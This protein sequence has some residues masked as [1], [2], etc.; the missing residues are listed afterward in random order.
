VHFK[1]K[2]P[3]RTGEVV[4]ELAGIEKAYDSPEG[5]RNVVYG[6]PAGKPLDLT[7]YRGDKVCL[8]GPNGAGKSTLLKIVADALAP[9]KGQ[10]K[11]G[12]HVSSAYYAQHQ[13]EQLDAGNTVFAELDRAA[14][15]WTQSEV[16]KLLGAFLFKG[17]DVEKKVSV[18]SGGEKSR[19]ALA[20]MLVEPAP[21]LCLDEP[22]NHLDIAS[23]DIL[24]AALKAYEGTL[25]FITHDRHLIRAVANRII[26]VKDGIVTNYD[27]D[28]DY[29]LSKTEDD[30]SQPVGDARKPAG[31]ARKPAGD[32]RTPVGATCGRAGDG[33]DASATEAASPPTPRR[34]KLA[35]TEDTGPKTKE[36][37]RAEAEARNRFAKERRE[38]KALEA[39]LNN[40]QARHDELVACM[41]SEELYNDKEAFDRTLTEYQQLKTLIPKLEEEWYSLSLLIEEK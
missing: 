25:V 9:D 1:F 10:R 24:E 16:R 4:V 5:G 34:A 3:P 27:G 20:K 2:Q 31:D 28:Y 6:P 15:S 8:V 26:E 21:L 12:V 32:V 41:A 33:Q 35:P 22:T 13:L 29:Y 30:A 37:K 39:K 36:Q 19:L 18:L 17:D 38:L 7:L 11:L 23:S 14:G 40:A